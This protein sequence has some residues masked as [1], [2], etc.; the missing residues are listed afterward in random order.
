[1]DCRPPGSSVHGVLQA[2]M[3]EGVALPPPGDL[4]EPGAEPSSLLSPAAAAGSLPLAPPG[5]PVFVSTDRGPGGGGCLGPAGPLTT[6]KEMAF[7]CVCAGPWRPASA[8]LPR[9]SPSL[10]QAAGERTGSQ[11][12]PPDACQVPRGLLRQIQEL[13]SCISIVWRF[14]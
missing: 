9:G 1:M 2:G 13:L 11:A 4:P 14:N 5:K 3:L 6:G 7:L 12:S 10:H 8:S